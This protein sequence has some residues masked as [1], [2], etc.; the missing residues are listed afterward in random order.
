M[1]MTFDDF[2]ERLRHADE[3]TIRGLN[4]CIV[5][6]R[7][8][9]EPSG[10]DGPHRWCV[11]AYVYPMHRMF[12][13]MH[14]HSR[15]GLEPYASMPLHGGCTLRRVHMG[16]F[17]VESIQVGADYNHLHDTAYTWMETREDAAP[18]FRDAFKLWNHFHEEMEE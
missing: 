8:K 7:H 1:S 12:A 9:V 5:V 13:A 10:G 3:W 2:S 11:Y 18:V 16:T 17:A 15:T 6:R 14:Q 4:Y